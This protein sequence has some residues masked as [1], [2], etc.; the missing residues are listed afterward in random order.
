MDIND[1]RISAIVDE[2]KRLKVAEFPNAVAITYRSLLD[3]SVTKYLEDNKEMKNV[4]AKNSKK[5]IRPHD[6][7][8]TL[9]MQLQYILDT[10][11]IPL[12]PSGRK[13]LALFLSDSQK[14]LTLDALNW[15]THIRYTPPIESQLRAFWTNLTPLHELTLQLPT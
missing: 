14:S 9:K 4:I 3:M 2:L 1:D 6:W 5:A 8:P 12:G 13:A 7:L 10:S 15:F 11:T